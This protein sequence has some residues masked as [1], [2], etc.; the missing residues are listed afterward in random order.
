MK[1]KEIK[2]RVRHIKDIAN[3]YEYA[4]DEEDLLVWDFV[5]YIAKTGTR[6]QRIKAKMVLASHRLPFARY[7]A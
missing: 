6:N 5:K 4:H 1:R 3:D 7:C 2:T